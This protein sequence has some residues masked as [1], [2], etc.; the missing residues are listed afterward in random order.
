MRIAASS[1]NGRDAAAS[2]LLFPPRRGLLPV[3]KRMAGSAAGAPASAR[4]LDRVRIVAVEDVDAAGEA[5]ES[6][7]LDAG[8][9]KQDRRAVRVLNLVGQPD[10]LRR[11]VAIPRRAM[12][13]ETRLVIDPQQSVQMLDALG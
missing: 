10:R 2:G 4:R 9:Q 11:G 13:Q 12:R 6:L 8:C 5:G 3:G 7:A 1:S